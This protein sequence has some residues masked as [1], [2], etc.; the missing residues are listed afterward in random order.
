MLKLI[1]MTLLMSGSTTVWAGS[2]SGYDYSSIL[3]T[4]TTKYGVQDVPIAEF[5]YISGGYTIANGQLHTWSNDYFYGDSGYRVADM[6]TGTI[7]TVGKP[8]F[9][10]ASNGYGDPFGLYDAQNDVFYAG[11]YD[12]AGGGMLKYNC[13]TK[14]WSSL[15][16]FNSLYGADVY[17]GEVYASG[18]NE[19]WNGS[20]GQANQIALYDLS[21][22]SS[23]DV[24][25]QATGNS[26][27]VAL[28][29]DGNLYYANYNGTSPSLYRWTKEQVDSVRADLGNGTTGGNENDLYLTYDDGEFLASLDGGANGIAVDDGGNVFITINGVSGTGGELVMWNETTGDICKT[30]AYMDVNAYG[31]LGYIDTVGDFL[32]G[33]TVY[34]NNYGSAGLVEVMMVPEPA[35]LLILISGISLM[36]KRF[37]Y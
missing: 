25:V 33:G 36:R 26:A 16:T 20:V 22:G 4:D 23:H 11:T 9:N 30:I 3:S 17:N 14:T 34:T 1:A 5:Y 21:G 24:L 12:D 28:D 18:L 19:I 32:H 7:T 37:I 27:C 31:W 2:V 15:G 6:K 8:S 35:S 10:I 13:K 29:R